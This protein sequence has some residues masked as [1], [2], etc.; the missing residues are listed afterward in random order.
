ML[1]TRDAHALYAK[2]GF[3]ELERPEIFM[4]IDRR[5]ED[6]WRG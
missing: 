1:A 6:L 4:A 3:D 5:P 2:L